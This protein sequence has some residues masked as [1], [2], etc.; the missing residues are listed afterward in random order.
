MKNMSTRQE[1]AN[2]PSK[3]N[4]QSPIPHM[5]IGDDTQTH[6]AKIYHAQCPLNVSIIGLGYVGAVSSACFASMGHDVI[7]VDIDENKVK[8]I[9]AGTSPILENKLDDLLYSAHKKGK[10]SATTSIR[11]AILKTSV[12]LISVST[13]SADDGSCNTAYLEKAV[14]TIGQA[15]RDK[16]NFHVL[17]FRST[18]PP[19]TTEDLLIPIIEKAS[20]K[21]RDIDFGTCFNPEFLREST[22]IKDFYNPPKTVIGSSDPK[23]AD[24]VKSLYG[25][26]EGECFVTSIKTAEFTKYIDNTWHALK[27]SFGNELGRLCKAMSVDSHEVMQIFCKDTHLNISPTYLMPGF[28]YGGSCLPKDTRGIAHMAKQLSIEL[29]IISHINASNETHIQHAIQLIDDCN[30]KTAAVIGLTFKPNTDDLRESPAL[31]LYKQL[32]NKGYQVLCFD[33]YI[34]QHQINQLEST[35]YKGIKADFTDSIPRIYNDADILVATHQTSYAQDIV[36]NAP[37]DM[38][39]ID[40][41]RLPKPLTTQTLYSGICW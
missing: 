15:L 39:I 28:A 16:D 7:G 6:S 10:L 34:S 18:V 32:K 31:I 12:T 17:V 14:E 40:L 24:I 21:K 11:D 3:N 13:P 41:A 1:T 4:E 38:H 2:D 19:S 27:V 30:K 35:D 5:D 33:P 29:P 23:S 36:R 20:G 8:L 37:K 22:A 25:N 9:N 26:V